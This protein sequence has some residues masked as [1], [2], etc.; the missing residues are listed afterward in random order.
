[1]YSCSHSEDAGVVCAGRYTLNSILAL[2]LKQ[3]H[4]QWPIEFINTNIMSSMQVGFERGPIHL[5]LCERRQWS[6]Q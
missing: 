3:V 4:S 1:M 6:F 5:L 2:I